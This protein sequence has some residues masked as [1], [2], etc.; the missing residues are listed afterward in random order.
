MCTPV[1]D[2]RGQAQRQELRA[3]WAESQGHAEIREG[4][5]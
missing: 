3:M 4:V 1:A 2:L 5:N